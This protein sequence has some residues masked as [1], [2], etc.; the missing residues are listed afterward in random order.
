MSPRAGLDRS[1][2]LQ[3]AGELADAHGLD[4]LTL[5]SL[6]KA[7]G[8]RS[9]SIYNHVEGLPELRHQLA[10][11]ALRQ[12]YDRMLHAAAG[13]AR[14]DA[15]H[16]IGRAYVEFAR[17]H[18]GLYEAALRAP[19]P[20]QEELTRI[21]EAI[22]KL[23]TDVLEPYGLAGDDAIHAVRALRSVLHG[24][25]SLEQKGG[26][27]L[28]LDLDETFR[29]MLDIVIAGIS[30]AAGHGPDQTSDG[31]DEGSHRRIRFS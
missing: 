30:R 5:A 1:K 12:L 18:P 3:T 27:G 13:R 31:H 21:S 26:F 15:I 4:N 14:D 9:P 10:V 2:I 25:A 20:G 22:V 16:A 11:H 6:A 7:L 24:F 17:E 28:P 8:I 29:R 19:A 23:L